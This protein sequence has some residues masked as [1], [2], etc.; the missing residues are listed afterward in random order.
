[1]YDK[2]RIKTIFFFCF[3]KIRKGNEKELERKFIEKT[4]RERNENAKQSRYDLGYGQSEFKAR[5]TKQ[6]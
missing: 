1:M 4:F 3:S 2:L 5:G 6:S